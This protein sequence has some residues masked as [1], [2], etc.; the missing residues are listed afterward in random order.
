MQF[1]AVFRFF[2]SP[3]APVL[4]PGKRFAARASAAELK[5]WAEE[6]LK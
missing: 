2:Y 6:Y 1:L 4:R 3:D 5:D